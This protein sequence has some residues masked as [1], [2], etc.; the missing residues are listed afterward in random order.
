MNTLGVG[1]RRKRLP[2]GWCLGSVNYHAQCPRVTVSGLEC[3]CECHSDQPSVQWDP[4]KPS[5]RVEPKPTPTGKKCLCGCG[6]DVRSNYRPGHDSRHLAHLVRQV[7]DMTI[8][9]NQARAALP[10]EA[11]KRKFDRVNTPVRK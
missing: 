1:Q 10:S 9:S 7:Q 4:P 2:L 8:N 6:E 3:V 11:L 5:T